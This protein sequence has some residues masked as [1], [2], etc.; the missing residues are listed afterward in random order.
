MAGFPIGAAAGIDELT[1]DPHPLLARLRRTEP[2]SWVPALDCWLVTSYAAA[3][4]VLRDPA[5]FTVDD[6]RFSTA[7]VVGTSMLSTDGVEH[8]RHR[9]PFARVFRPAEVHGRFTESIA[10]RV[11]DLLDVLAPAGVGD[12]RTQLAGPLAVGVVADV[13]GLAVATDTV[14]AWYAAISDAV[15]GVSAGHDVTA[16]GRAA[17]DA[18]A[19]RVRAAIGGRS[20]L[21]D[22][23]RDGLAVDDAVANAAVLMFGGIDTTEG[24]I[25]NAVLH[26]LTYRVDP[27][28]VADLV[29]ESIR[30]EPAA[31][32]LDRYATRDVE[33]AG[34]SIR[35]GDPV[36]VSVSGANRDPLVFAEPDRFDVRRVNLRQHLAFA[37]GPHFCLGAD[38]ARLET[39]AVIEA[40]SARLPAL[41]LDPTRPATPRGLVFRKPP[42]LHVRWESGF[43]R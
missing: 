27:D 33:L 16:D 1:T 37:R 41:R 2:V 30:F 24:M 23:V 14:L 26:L 9:G 25:T 43:N 18:L 17:F 4:R 12:V 42:A 36:T 13:L 10:T 40:V 32:A 5:T 8:T 22:V 19:E 29:E 34:A 20:L 6:P 7:Q 28:E 31:A 35:R 38:L 21:A 3:D 39:R 11:R 15:S